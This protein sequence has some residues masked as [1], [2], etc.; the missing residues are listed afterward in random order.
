[1]S[2]KAKRIALTVVSLLVLSC[3]CCATLSTLLILSRSGNGPQSSNQGNDSVNNT[4][5]TT[6]TNFGSNT[7]NTGNT[8]CAGAPTSR[9]VK[10]MKGMVSNT[11]DHTPTR[12]RQTAGTTGKLLGSYPD[13]TPF[14]VQDSDPICR[15]GYLWWSVRLDSGP[16]GWMAEGNAQKYFIEPR[17]Q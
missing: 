4:Q 1:M 15:D 13:G 2:A 7:G 9:M 11:P 3:I 6:V 17:A 5:P 16:T 8:S 10:G 14:T 12:L